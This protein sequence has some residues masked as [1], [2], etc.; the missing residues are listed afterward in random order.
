MLSP[1]KIS[2]FWKNCAQSGAVIPLYKLRIPS[3]RIVRVK[4]DQADVYAPGSVCSRILMRSRGWPIMIPM[5]PATPPQT[6]FFDV[7]SR[8]L[9]SSFMAEKKG[10]LSLIHIHLLQSRVSSLLDCNRWRCKSNTL[11]IS[12][13]QSADVFMFLLITP[14]GIRL[15]G[16][17]P[18]ALLYI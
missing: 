10:K 15:V 17:I 9:T 16:S 18:N 3:S 13:T 5:V 14:A 7:C 8:A 12:N 1:V 2:P 4:H 6:N 11:Q